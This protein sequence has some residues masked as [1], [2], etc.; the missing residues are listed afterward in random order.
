MADGLPTRRYASDVLSSVNRKHYFWPRKDAWVGDGD[1]GRHRQRRHGTRRTEQAT[2][3]IPGARGDGEDS[4]ATWTTLVWLRRR[5]AA[6]VACNV[7]H[8]LQVGIPWECCS[9]VDPWPLALNLCGDRLRKIWRMWPWRYGRGGATPPMDGRPSAPKKSRIRDAFAAKTTLVFVSLLLS[10][11][12]AVRR[13]CQ[14]SPTMKGE[15]S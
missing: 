11:I 1:V 9:A 13:T 7:S 6:I 2:S 12:L 4:T 14:T 3:D 10:A 5:R 8:Q 15:R